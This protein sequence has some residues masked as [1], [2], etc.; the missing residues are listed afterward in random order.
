MNAADLLRISTAVLAL[1]AAAGSGAPAVRPPPAQPEFTRS[2]TIVLPPKPTACDLVVLTLPP[3]RPFVELGTW[4]IHD[5]SSSTSQV[6]GRLR[7][8]TCEEGGD[9]LILV[10]NGYGYYIKATALHWTGPDAP[11]SGAT[12]PQPPQP[13]APPAPQPEPQPNL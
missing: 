4:D 11:P 1:T 8:R 5:P 3:Q 2:T 9:A 6:V 7:A 12:A 13:E 10:A